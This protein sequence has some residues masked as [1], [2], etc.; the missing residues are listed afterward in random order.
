MSLHW[1]RLMVKSLKFKLLC[2]SLSCRSHDFISQH[3]YIWK[4]PWGQLCAGAPVRHNITEWRGKSRQGLTWAMQIMNLWACW[5]KIVENLSP[6][7]LTPPPTPGH[8]TTARAPLDP[9]VTRDIHYT[10]YA[11]RLCNLLRSH[12]SSQL[13]NRA[14]L[15]ICTLIASSTGNRVNCSICIPFT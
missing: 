11:I 5:P 1:P 14:T 8:G 2:S 12:I 7:G 6:S 3:F 10:C 4:C 15:A 9:G 13:S